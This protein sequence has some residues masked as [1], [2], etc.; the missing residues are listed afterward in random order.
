MKQSRYVVKAPSFNGKSTIFYNIRSNVGLKVPANQITRFQEL[1]NI[2]AFHKVLHKYHF[3][4]TPDEEEEVFVEHQKM[5]QEEHPFHL[6]ILPHQNCNFRCVYCYEKFE[7]NKM[8]PHIE[9]GIIKLVEERI[10]SNRYKIFTVTWFGGEPLLAVD[11]IERLSRQFQEICERYGVTYVASITT[12]G[13]NLTPSVIDMLLESGVVSFQVTIDGTKECHDHQRILKGGQPTYNRIIENLRELSTRT[14][15]YRVLLRMNVGQ[16]NIQYADQHILDMK[17]F[18]GHDSRFVIGFHNIG[19]WG[20]ENDENV[21]ICPENVTLDLTHRTIDQGMNADAIINKVQSYSPCYA[22]SPHSFVI[23][24][25]G[26]VYKCTVALYDERNHVGMIDSSGNMVL[27]EERMN[28]WTESS[29][30]D[31]TCKSCYYSPA[32]HGESCPLVRIANGKRPCPDYKKQMKE[33]VT[34]M[35]RQNYKFIDLTPLF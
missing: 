20:G 33:I 8:L 23:G 7:K 16:D 11:V 21:A 34:L 17:R 6:I 10:R 3:F 31:S 22:A 27:N 24:V 18:F 29:V 1:A 30:D 32:C 26:M 35:D 25:D 15:P 19:H 14:N 9:E 5:K 12:N 2:K 4:A 28:L 13:Y